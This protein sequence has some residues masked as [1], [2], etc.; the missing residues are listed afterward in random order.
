MFAAAAGQSTLV[1]QLL[2]AGAS[3]N[4]QTSSGW[5]A[6]SRAALKGHEAVV[7]CL[8]AAGAS[9]EIGKAGLTSINEVQRRAAID[10]L[11]GAVAAASCTVGSS[12][13][14]A[15]SPAASNDNSAH[16]R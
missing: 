11:C 12:L 6:L 7:Q 14:V 15:A 5:S 9:V 16:P 1:Q 13:A 2:T 3:V 4:A 8:L 10:L